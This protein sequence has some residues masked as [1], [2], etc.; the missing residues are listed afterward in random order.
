[1]RKLA[2]KEIIEKDG[3][4]YEVVRVV[5]D[6]K[7]KVV[8]DGLGDVS[9]YEKWYNQK[10]CLEA[11]KNDG[12]ALRYVREQSE[13]VCL[14]AV[15]NYGF[16]LQYVREQSEAVCLEAVKSDGGAL[17]YVDKRVFKKTTK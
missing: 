5:D 10:Y 14:E 17:Q 11:V 4:R 8:I 12:F 3:V 7:K 16:A 2:K 13:A 15:K 9:Q 1:M 6:E